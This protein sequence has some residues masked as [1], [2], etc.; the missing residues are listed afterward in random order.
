MAL[1]NLPKWLFEVIAK[2]MQEILSERQDEKWPS[3]NLR[4]V[5]LKEC[6]DEIQ[7]RTSALSQV[8]G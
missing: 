1:E 6:L 8:P 7:K 5:V 2:C 4:R 3:Y